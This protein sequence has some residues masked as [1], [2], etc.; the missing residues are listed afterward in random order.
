MQAIQIQLPAQREHICVLQGMAL[1]LFQA[2][3]VR[4]YTYSLF[5]TFSTFL[6]CF[7]WTGTSN[8]VKPTVLI[9]K[10]A[11][12]VKTSSSCGCMHVRVIVRIFAIYKRKRSC[13]KLWR[14]R[15]L[16]TTCG[17]IPAYVMFS[18]CFDWLFSFVVRA[19]CGRML[20]WWSFY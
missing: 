12:Q 3:I 10:V 1:T 11:K 5:A 17:R 9:E 19:Y 14:R 2:H 20:E 4:M 7:V 16:H 15:V 13:V 8:R 6:L 18:V